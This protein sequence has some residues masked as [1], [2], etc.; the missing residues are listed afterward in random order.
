M[1]ARRL[2]VFGE[3]NAPVDADQGNVVLFFGMHEFRVS[4][5]F[6]SIKTRNKKKFIFNAFLRDELITFYRILLIV[7]FH[8]YITILRSFAVFIFIKQRQLFTEK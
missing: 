1:Q 6:L 4:Y 7:I 8:L 5:D 3:P 2:D